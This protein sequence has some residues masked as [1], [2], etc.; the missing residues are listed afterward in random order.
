MFDLPGYVA[1]KLALLGVGTVVDTGLDTRALPEHFFSYRR[2][3]LAGETQYGRQLSA[4]G[5]GA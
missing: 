4:I 5:L 1:A 3:T 2:M